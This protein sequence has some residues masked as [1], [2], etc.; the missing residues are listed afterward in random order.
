MGLHGTVTVAGRTGRQSF[1]C[2]IAAVTVVET[3]LQAGVMGLLQGDQVTRFALPPP[4]GLIAAAPQ[5][6]TTADPAVIASQLAAIPAPDAASAIVLPAPEASPGPHEVRAAGETSSEAAEPSADAAAP[7]SPP[8]QADA[9]PDTSTW[10]PP[11]TPAAAKRQLPSEAA[12]DA[13]TAALENVPSVSADDDSRRD[14]GTGPDQSPASASPAQ[15]SSQAVASMRSQPTDLSPTTAADGEA[16]A[17]R[18]D[19]P[20]MA[21]TAGADFKSVA[22]HNTPDTTRSLAELKASSAVSHQSAAA[23]AVPPPNVQPQMETPGVAEGRVATPLDTADI[24]SG[25]ARSTSRSTQLLPGL[26]DAH[27]AQNKEQ[28]SQQH[29]QAAEQVD[30]G[31]LGPLG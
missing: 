18:H 10:P 17:E 27:D 3:G 6:P 30:Y 16:A 26:P 15:A 31:P 2:L 9:Q 22:A 13:H 25:G 1:F 4:P 21:S 7:L 29:Q 20:E 14:K 23:A 8:L 12:A 24:S 28:S 19:V 11:M 5:A